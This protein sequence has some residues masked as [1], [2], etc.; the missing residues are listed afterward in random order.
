MSNCDCPENIKKPIGDGLL[1][2]TI[3][4]TVAGIFFGLRRVGVGQQG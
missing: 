2:T 1:I 3:A 4:A